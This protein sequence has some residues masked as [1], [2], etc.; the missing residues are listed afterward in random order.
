M[1]ISQIL[2]QNKLNKQMQ[3]RNTRNIETTTD[4]LSRIIPEDNLEA[5]AALEQFKADN[6]EVTPE[7]KKLITFKYPEKTLQQAEL[8]YHTRVQE[9]ELNW[10]IEYNQWNQNVYEAYQAQGNNEDHPPGEEDERQAT[11][12]RG[13]IRIPESKPVHI[14]P[15]QTVIKVGDTHCEIIMERELNRETMNYEWIRKG[16]EILQRSEPN[17]T[18][19][20]DNAINYENREKTKIDWEHTLQNL[21][22]HGETLGYTKKHFLRC[23]LRILSQHNDDLFMTFKEEEDPEKIGNT[24]LAKYIGINKKKLYETKLRSLMRKQGQPIREV[25]GQVDILADRILH[26]CKDPQ[27]KEYRKSQIMLDALKSFSS[28]ENAKE[29]MQALRGQSLSGERP[30]IAELIDTVELAEKLKEGTR[31]NRDLMFMKEGVGEECSIFTAQVSPNDKQSTGK[32]ARSESKDREN[33]Q[34]MENVIKRAEELHMTGNRYTRSKERDQPNNRQRSNERR[35]DRSPSWNRQDR[36]TNGP[37]ERLR[38]Q[39]FDRSR[40]GDQRENSREKDN[41]YRGGRD[42]SY[43]GGRD[44]Y[45]GG[46]DNF[47]GGR[48]NF[49]GG[50]DN[51]R[52]G[53]D[54]YRGERESFRG[55]DYERGRDY[56]RN[57]DNY[58]GGQP[59]RE[60]D[61]SRNRSQS[62]GRNASRDRF[63][64]K[65]SYNSRERYN[66]TERFNTRDRDQS[67]DRNQSRERYEPARGG[68]NREPSRERGRENEKKQQWGRDLQPRGR[69]QNRGHAEVVPSNKKNLQGVEFPP[70]DRMD[71]KNKFCVK[72]MNSLEPHWPWECKLYRYWDQSP[73]DTC[74]NGQ[75]RQKECRKNPNRVDAF[76]LLL[77]STQQGSQQGLQQTPNSS[78]SAPFQEH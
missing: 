5:N 65:D 9:A 74:Y 1:F 4:L 75:H 29:L 22:E 37:R 57:R 62:W 7:R 14:K 61:Q 48:D 71:L 54:N 28:E 53:R 23:L 15:T 12:P 41:S 17:D 42:N 45:R 66:S 19:M 70:L 44:N 10:R 46:R 39:S 8:E 33:Q 16:M 60:R 18:R 38:S 49:R 67:R 59:S 11:V 27:E 72:C 51:Y 13:P 2:K 3:E 52:G 55:G 20:E 43:R 73:C 68:N 34:K 69:S 36:R 32:T 21:K 26:K 77:E 63:N 78:R 76:S 47:R 25:M 31:P 6:L 64:P 58:T 56:F 30:D 50:R 40:Q 35:N 24:L